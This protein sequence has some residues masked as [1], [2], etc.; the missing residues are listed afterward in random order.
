MYKVKEN[1]VAN[2]RWPGVAVL[3]VAQEGKLAGFWITE[4]IF[5]EQQD[6]FTLG[7][8]RIMRGKSCFTLFSLFL[9]IS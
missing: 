3:E 5:V 4:D 2:L 6:L 9:K 8:L 1:G 7:N